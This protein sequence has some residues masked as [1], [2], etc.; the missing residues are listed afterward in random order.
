METRVV[1]KIDGKWRIS[2]DKGEID[3]RELRSLQNYL[4]EIRYP[5]QIDDN[6]I[7]F[8]GTLGWN[9]VC[10]RLERFYD[11][12]AEGIRFEKKEVSQIS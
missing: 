5:Y 2:T 7:G 8:E 4:A 3:F 12:M 6:G 10:E 1:R 9:D 11:G